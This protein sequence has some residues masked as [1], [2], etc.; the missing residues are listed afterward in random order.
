M[1]KQIFYALPKLVSEFEDYINFQGDYDPDGYTTDREE[2]RL[3]VFEER[4]RDILPDVYTHSFYTPDDAFNQSIRYLKKE[5]D[6]PANKVTL[7]DNDNRIVL[8]TLYQISDASTNNVLTIKIN[9]VRRT[10][11]LLDQV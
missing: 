3:I 1:K 4:I 8:Y 9:E 11:H 2:D 5:L 10:I 7:F 6:V